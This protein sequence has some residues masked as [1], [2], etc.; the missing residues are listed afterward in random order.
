MKKIFLILFF[1][2]FSGCQTTNN[3]KST[4]SKLKIGENSVNIV[5][6]KFLQAYSDILSSKVPAK[7]IITGKLYLPKPCSAQK[8]PAV[9]IQFF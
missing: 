5:S 9:I 2:A 8:M 4:Q 1:L 3:V 6:G 7:K